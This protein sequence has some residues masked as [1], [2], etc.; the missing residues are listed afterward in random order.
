MIPVDKKHDSVHKTNAI[1][2]QLREDLAKANEVIE[3]LEV[4]YEKSQQV[5]KEL[6]T[7][8]QAEKIL[9]DKLGNAR[10]T[11]EIQHAQA[12]WKKAREV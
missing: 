12:L 8:L 1:I 6:L 7:E 2:K 11:S 10:Y 5:E 4:S 3:F 9:C